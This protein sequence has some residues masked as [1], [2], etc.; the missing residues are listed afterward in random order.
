MKSILARLAGSSFNPPPDDRLLL[1]LSHWLLSLRNAKA[2]SAKGSRIHALQR[3]GTRTSHLPVLEASQTSFTTPAGH[4]YEWLKATPPPSLF[5]F[6][7]GRKNHRNISCGTDFKIAQLLPICTGRLLSSVRQ[8]RGMQRRGQSGFARR[9][10]NKYGAKL[11]R[12]ARIKM[13]RLT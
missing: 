1:L 5:D 6:P 3:P 10:G 9:R 7:C 4:M 2:I 12:P 11:K 13:G 8:M